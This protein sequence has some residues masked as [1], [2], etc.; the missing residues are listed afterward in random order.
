MIQQRMQCY[1]KPKTQ[2]PT[3]YKPKQGQSQALL[4]ISLFLQAEPGNSICCCDRQQVFSF[5]LE[6][7]GFS[8]GINLSIP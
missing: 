5:R 8:L 3:L 2:M 7:S 6:L 1:V 4:T